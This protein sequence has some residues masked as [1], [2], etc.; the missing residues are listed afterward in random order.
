MLEESPPVPIGYFYW[1]LYALLI[2]LRLS[3]VILQS[4]GYLHPDEFFQSIEIATY[5]IY[6][7]A[8][9]L[10]TW[11]FE[12]VGHGPV[13]S[14]SSIYP[15]V[16]LPIKAVDYLLPSKEVS[17]L[18]GDDMVKRL[19]LPPRLITTLFSFIPDAFI[20]YLSKKMEKR[21]QN[22]VPFA[23]LLYSSMA[24]GGLL[25]NTRT[26][27]NVWESAAVC[28]F[29][30]LS[31]QTTLTAFII[32]AAISAWAVFLRPTF[33]IF[34]LPFAGLQLVSMLRS[35]RRLFNVIF[36]IPLGLF[37]AYA[38]ATLLA[39]LD[40]KYYS[41]D[42]LITHPALI[43]T[44]IRFLNYNSAE[45]TLGEHGLHP[46]YHYILIHWPLMLTP[47]L[48]LIALL[49]PSRRGFNESLRFAV[50]F[51]TILPTLALSLIGHKETRFL[52]PSLP[53]AVTLAA[54]RVRRLKLLLVFW[55]AYQAIMVAF[56]GFAHQ[57]GL[58]SFVRSIPPMDANEVSLNIFYR[59]YMPPRFAF[60]E[61]ASPHLTAPLECRKL[62]PFDEMGCTRVIDF[63]GR[64]ESEVIAFLDCLKI[65]TPVSMV[66]R[67]IV[68]GT[69][70]P[71]Q[72]SLSEYGKILRVGKYFPHLSV[73]NLPSLNISSCP[74]NVN[75][76][77][78]LFM[79]WEQ[80]KAQLS[81]YSYEIALS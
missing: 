56:W 6:P 65:Y 7:N 21:R 27:S 18:S 58:L 34:I 76:L 59:T 57:A 55:V 2:S 53:F 3:F 71:P 28:I 52:F 11:E 49:P 42:N 29:C 62:A 22:K 72:K 41:K 48:A 5:D 23:L 36:F 19:L 63:A 1:G 75:L 4:P 46:W 70:L 47:P 38:A 77:D 10:R 68:P 32:Q 12:P 33:P 64:P 54:F 51:A 9:S 67:L 80:L 31:F 69:V 17:Q 26:L 66:V 15:F 8:C 30:Y 39:F 60:G 16:H 44:P 43:V 79:Y 78:C 74:T 40:T 73:E 61:P 81:L 37:T 14:R 20:L 24:Y 45:K 35:P 13:R 25:W 50:W